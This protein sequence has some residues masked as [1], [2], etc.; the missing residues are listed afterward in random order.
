M[1]QRFFSRTGF[2]QVFIQLAENGFVGDQLAGLIIHHQNIYLFLLA[3][4]LPLASSLSL[5]KIL[6]RPLRCPLP[7]ATPVTLKVP[8]PRAANHFTG[9]TTSAT[10]KAIARC[11]PAS[12]D[13]RKRPLPGISRGPLSWL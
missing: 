11:S 3:H 9:G 1:I 6:R 2:D 8:S 10:R 7:A 13:T 5:Q 4:F 12:P